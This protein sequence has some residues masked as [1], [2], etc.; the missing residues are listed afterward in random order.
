MGVQLLQ[1]IP[2]PNTYITDAYNAHM[3][4]GDGRYVKG[5][6]FVGHMG[7]RMCAECICVRYNA[8]THVKNV[9]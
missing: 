4:A 5:F 2:I 1:Y 3:C 6:F 7:A 9:I 8:Y